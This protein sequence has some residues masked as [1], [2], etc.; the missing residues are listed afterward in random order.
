MKHVKLGR[1]AVAGLVANVLSFIVGGGGY[2]LFGWVFELEP[3]GVWKWSP[4]KTAEMSFGWWA[5]LIGGNTL[6]AIVYALVYAVLYHGIPGTGFRKG[7]VFGLIVWLVGVV[8]AIFTMYVLV[9]IHGGA[10]LYFLTQSLVEHLVYGAAVAL[11][12]GKPALRP[13]G[14]RR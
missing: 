10:L 9:N 14:P 12:Y 2:Q 8:P 11:I 7:L 4:E 3:R 6:L 13:T 5:F 1:A